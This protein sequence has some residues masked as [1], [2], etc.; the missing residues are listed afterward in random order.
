MKQKFER[1]QKRLMK[2]RAFLK[3]KIDKALDKFIKK[4]E[5]AQDN[6]NQEKQKRSYNRHHINRKHH[7]RLPQTAKLQKI[8]KCRGN[9]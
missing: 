3:D 7:K 4:K 8:R 1:Q 2:L 5:K 9:G 6:Q